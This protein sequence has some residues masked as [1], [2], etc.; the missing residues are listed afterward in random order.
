MIEWYFYAHFLGIHEAMHDKLG[1]TGTRKE[2]IRCFLEE[3]KFDGIELTSKI[4]KDIIRAV[5]IS[6]I[7]KDLPWR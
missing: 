7:Y 6:D 1:H 5:N 4:I 2:E 3:M